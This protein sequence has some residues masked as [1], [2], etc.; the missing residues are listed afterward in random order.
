MINPLLFSPSPRDIPAVLELWETLQYDHLVEKYM[1]PLAAYQAGRQYFL[2]HK[3]YTH[4]VV[5]PDDL[6]VTE[7]VLN[8][9]VSDIMVHNY[10]VIAG[11]C[12]MDEGQP[13]LYN[14]QAK[15]ISYK[16]N[17]PPAFKDSWI[18]RG[19]LPAEPI[20]EV[21]FAGFGCEF[22]ERSVMEKVSF[23]G[24]TNDKQGNFDWQ[25]TRECV[26]MGIP[27]MVDQRANIWHRRLEQSKEA[28][29]VN[30]GTVH[31]GEEKE[32]LIPAHN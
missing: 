6:E 21:G 20:F 10:P 26:S 28:K 18:R 2:E 11:M 15:G 4:L 24:A 29:A 14:I 9:L 5:C 19:K 1:R 16:D 17:K 27:I 23:T 8:M 25:F 7:T 32:F 12:N 3:E 13:E 30:N 31:M 22:I